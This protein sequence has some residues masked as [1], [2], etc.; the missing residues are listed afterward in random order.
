MQTKTTSAAPTKNRISGALNATSP[1][2]L[3]KC[4]T[5]A[6]EHD[7]LNEA[8]RET[9][10]GLSK[11]AR[12]T[13]TRARGAMF[14]FYRAAIANKDVPLDRMDALVLDEN[15]GEVQFLQIPRDDVETLRGYTLLAARISSDE[16]PK[17]MRFALY[18][19]FRGKSAEIPSA[20][21]PTAGEF[22]RGMSKKIAVAIV[23]AH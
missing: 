1:A 10:R 7:Y 17:K 6:L 9:L 23:N 13:N 2:E 12:L 4:V 15:T 11:E 21:L 20:F 14:S 18:L 5:A 8:T 19:Y 3:I 22:R 16:E